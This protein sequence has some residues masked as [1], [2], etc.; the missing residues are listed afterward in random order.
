MKR[1]SVPIKRQYQNQFRKHAGQKGLIK[2]LHKGL[3]IFPKVFCIK[4]ELFLYNCY[5]LNDE[6]VSIGEIPAKNY[7]VLFYTNLSSQ[8]VV[9]YLIDDYKDFFYQGKFRINHQSNK[10]KKKTN[11]SGMSLHEL[12]KFH[13]FLFDYA[14]T[15]FD[16]YTQSL[17]KKAPNFIAKTCDFCFTITFSYDTSNRAQ[18]VWENGNEKLIINHTLKGVRVVLKFGNKLIEGTDLD[19]VPVQYGDEFFS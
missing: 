10:N 8:V 16:E 3:K 11:Y 12:L 9:Q 4:T 14:D 18:M 5:R 6:V 7:K 2:H 13:Q 17:K 15:N 1:K 19:N